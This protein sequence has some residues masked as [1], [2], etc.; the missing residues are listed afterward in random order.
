MPATLNCPSCGAA[1]N[2]GATTCEYCGSGLVAIACRACFGAMFAGAQF[3]PHCGAKAEQAK[4]TDQST[5]ACPGCG[6]EMRHAQVNGDTT[7]YECAGC[8]A[9]WLTPDMFT[10]LCADREARG[11]AVASSAAA[12][13]LDKRKPMR[14]AATGAVT[15]YVRC[16]VCNARMNRVNFGDTSG[17]IVD[18]CTTHGIWFERDELHAILTFVEEGGLARRRAEAQQ[19]G[20]SRHFV[21]EMHF[22]TGGA[23]G[24]GTA[25]REIKTVTI[26]VDA[27]TRISGPAS[28]SDLLKAFFE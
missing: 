20:T 6:G 22:G 19:G 25:P 11:D 8:G 5:L 26:R 18:T 1:A 27:S 23:G 17:V 7:M 2:D 4:Q 10:K 13:G 9:A 12:S 3:C 15:R 14:L 16:P 28:W 24:G 21:R